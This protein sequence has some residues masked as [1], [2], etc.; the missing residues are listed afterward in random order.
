MKIKQWPNQLGYDVATAAGDWEVLKP[1][2]GQPT[3]AAFFPTGSLYPTMS[4]CVTADDV[5]AGA[6]E[7]EELHKALAEMAG[8]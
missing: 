2:T 3:R 8:L 4:V 6:I 7:Y 5:L 1:G